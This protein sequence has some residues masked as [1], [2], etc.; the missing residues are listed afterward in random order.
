MNSIG[1]LDSGLRKSHK[2]A[3]VSQPPL[4]DTKICRRVWRHIFSNP[5]QYGREAAVI[6]FAKSRGVIHIYDFSNFPT[7]KI[8]WWFL[9]CHN[10]TTEGEKHENYYARHFMRRHYVLYW[11]WIWRTFQVRQL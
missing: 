10:K 1:I 2:Y 7:A 8:F 3:A 4:S 9:L 5:D 6:R 11:S